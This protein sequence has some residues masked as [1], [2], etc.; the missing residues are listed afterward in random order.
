MKLELEPQFVIS[1]PAPG[2][3]LISN[4]WLPA[5]QHWL[6]ADQKLS[7]PKCGS[8]HFRTIFE[9]RRELLALRLHILNATLNACSS[10]SRGRE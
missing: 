8:H 4:P 6:A 2:G 7:K 5:M 10:C 9:Y 1:I 3:I